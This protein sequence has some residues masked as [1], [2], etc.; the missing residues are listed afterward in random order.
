[1]ANNM[2]IVTGHTGTPH[3]TGDDDGVIRASIFGDDDYILD[4]GNKL[5]ADIYS[6]LTVRVYDGYL[7]MQ[8]RQARVN[9]GDY[10]DLS[11]EECS[12]VNK[13]RRDAIVAEYRNDGTYEY[14][15]LQIVKGEEGD[16]YVTPA[17]VQDSI[18]DG[19][20]KNQTL[21]YYVDVYGYSIATINDRRPKTVDA[22][23]YTAG[24]GIKI[25]GKTIELSL[26]YAETKSF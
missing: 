2:Q 15:D 24:Y 23:Q 11:F 1:M 18:F 25:T 7:L 3:V 20:I 21:L 9:K 8:G 17:L 14:I 5:D 19:A 4:F 16:D 13:K 22:G 10:Y 26:E 6:D 12:A